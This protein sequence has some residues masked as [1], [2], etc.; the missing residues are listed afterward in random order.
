MIHFFTINKE[1]FG[2]MKKLEQLMEYGLLDEKSKSSRAV[3]RLFLKILRII[4]SS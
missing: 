2:K 1:T 4:S 3:T